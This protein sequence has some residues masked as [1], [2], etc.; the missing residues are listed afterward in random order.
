VVLYGYWVTQYPAAVTPT[1]LQLSTAEPGG[2]WGSVAATAPLRY[3]ALPLRA[4]EGVQLI[5]NAP[6]PS[7]LTISVAEVPQTVFAL[8]QISAGDPEPATG[9]FRVDRMD[10]ASGLSRW[11]VTVRPP[12]VFLLS[13]TL[14]RYTISVTNVS[15]N[16]FTTGTA[17]TSAPLV[18]TLDT[19]PDFT[20][21]VAIDG[22]G[23]VTS[24]LPGISCPPNCQFIFGSYPVTLNPGSSD[25][26]TDR[27]LG[28]TGNCSGT[29]VCNLVLTGTAVFAVAHFGS[30]SQSIEVCPQAPLIPGWTW[31][32]QPNCGGVEFATRQCDATGYYCCGSSGGRATPRCPNETAVTCSTDPL[33]GGPVNQRLF[34]PGGCYE[35]TSR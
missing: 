23:H 7:S 25:P 3:F 17:R 16:P 26:G 5:L 30:A 33:T 18:V 22:P 6:Q 2:R 9:Y 15:H 13:Q 34:Q 12:E 20:V 27:F 11:F 1:L 32:T 10:T 19:R 4:P 21:T 24:D 31:V 28:W 8:A 29:N 35:V 14:T